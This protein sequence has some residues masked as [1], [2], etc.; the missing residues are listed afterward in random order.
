MDSM[1]ERD[2]IYRAIGFD[3][4]RV[5]FRK[6]RGYTGEKEMSHATKDGT[7]Y[8]IRKDPG[9]YAQIM[10]IQ[11]SIPHM[12]KFSLPEK[13]YILTEIAP[14]TLLSDLDIIPDAASIEKQ[15]TEFANAA[16]KHRLVHGDIRQWN[17]LL[18]TDGS[19]KVI[20]WNSGRFGDSDIDTQDIAK[21]GQLMRGEIGFFQAW[22]WNP[23]E[24]APWHQP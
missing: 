21:L 6:F 8:F 9:L 14:G 10:Q 11:D 5:R 18:H 1:E 2:L 19:I 23:A 24:C 13:G 20:D 22:K 7:A 3:V 17:V 16:K 15:L 4:K 12:A